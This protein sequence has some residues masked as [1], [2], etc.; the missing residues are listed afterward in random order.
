M[1]MIK[2]HKGSFA[3]S[4]EKR[5]KAKEK[6]KA[7]MRGTLGLHVLIISLPYLN[8]STLYT[9]SSSYMAYYWGEMLVLQSGGEHEKVEDLT[10][11]PTAL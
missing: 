8:K 4:E 6:D 2:V 1:N 11:S 9:C 7:E 3:K 5:R 10:D